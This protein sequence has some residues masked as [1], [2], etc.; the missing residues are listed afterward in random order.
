MDWNQIAKFTISVLASFGSGWAAA[1][2][3]DVSAEK[4]LASGIVAAAAYILG[5]RQTTVS[6]TK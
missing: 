3:T 5:N 2:L 4:A 6:L 1:I